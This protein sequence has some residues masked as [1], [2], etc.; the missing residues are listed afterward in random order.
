MTVAGA[1][2]L[3]ACWLVPV[4]FIALA[5][6]VTRQI[7]G[8]EGAPCASGR[9]STAGDSQPWVMFFR[10]RVPRLLPWTRL[11]RLRQRLHRRPALLAVLLRLRVSDLLLRRAVRSLLRRSGDGLRGAT[12][13]DAVLLPEHRLL[14]ERSDVPAGLA[15]RRARFAAPIARARKARVCVSA[16]RCAEADRCPIRPPTSRRRGPAVRAR[17]RRRGRRETT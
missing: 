6:R 10:P 5:L 16:C 17:R 14:P 3:W 12:A 9:G 1:I 15:S 4:L 11:R 8:P 7:A 2:V 13:R